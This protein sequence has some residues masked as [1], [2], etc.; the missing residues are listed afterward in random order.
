M[1]STKPPTIDTYRVDNLAPID[2]ELYYYPDFLAASSADTLYNQLVT[3]LEWKQETLTI[4]GKQVTTPR[5]VCWY[6]DPGAVYRYSG[7]DHHPVP[8]N[9]T[10]M[11]IKRQ[12]EQFSGYH[13][14][15]VLGNF[16]RDGNDSM[17]WHADKE[18]QLGIN[19]AIVSLSLG[20]ER[21]FKL[22]H[23]KNSH[24]IDIK[25]EHGSILVMAS[26]LQHSWRH[27]LPKTRQCTTPRIN[28]TF[29]FIIASCS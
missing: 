11:Q 1:I 2:G 23:N 25:L 6:G 10:L 27:C 13:F 26:N 16:Y 8:W 15:S 7:V 21:L 22:R 12:I 19:P 14:N 5:L 18:K 29:R 3:Q 28:L 4:M 17:G 20:A 24:N 9:K